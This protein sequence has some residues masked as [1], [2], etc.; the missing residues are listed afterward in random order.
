MFDIGARE[1]NVGIME[2]VSSSGSV[3]GSTVVQQQKQQ[4]HA[5]QHKQVTS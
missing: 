2:T 3:A 4:Q 5:W 1:V